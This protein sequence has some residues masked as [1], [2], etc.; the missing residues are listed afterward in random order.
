MVIDILKVI[1]NSLSPRLESILKGKSESEK[2]NMV[3]M[4]EKHTSIL[5][6][7]VQ[8]EYFKK[9]VLNVGFFRQF[10][11]LFYPVGYSIKAVGNDGIEVENLPG[12]WRKQFFS[13]RIMNFTD[14][15]NIP[16]DLEKLITEFNAIQRVSR[17]DILRFYIEF[18]Q[19]HPFG[20]SNGTI[21][22]VLADVQCAVY[23]FKPFKYLHIRFRDKPFLFHTIELYARDSSMNGLTKILDEIDSFHSSQDYSTLPKW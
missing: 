13:F 20:D 14:C 22:A 9:G 12:E 5:A 11:T 17:E 18:G 3:A 10:H 23:G 4:F 16:R 7:F 15:K 6:E 19:V 1:R 2:E 8:N 21:S